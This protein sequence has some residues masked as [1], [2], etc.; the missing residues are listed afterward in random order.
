[1]PSSHLFVCVRGTEIWVMFDVFPT[2]DP[3]CELRGNKIQ[4]KAMTREMLFA[5]EKW[6]AGILCK[7]PS[8]ARM[9]V[10]LD[11]V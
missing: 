11:T 3:A 7:T 1:M 10:R 6:L 2:K 9:T 4:S 8:C 5:C